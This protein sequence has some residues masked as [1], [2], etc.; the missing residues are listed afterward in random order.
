MSLPEAVRAVVVQENKTTA[1]KNVPIQ[2]PGENEILVKVKAVAINPTDWKHVKWPMLNKAGAY[3]GCDFAGEVVQVGPNLRANVKVGDRVASSVRGGVSRERGAFSEYAKTFADLTFV[4][5]EGTWSFEE[6]STIG[7]P[8]Y[9]SIQ[10]LYGPRTLGLPQ[11]GDRPPAPGTWF[12]V[13]GGSS[14]VGQYAIQ[15]AK[16]SGYK[17]ATVASPHNFGLVKGLGADV[18]FDYMDPGV[19]KKLK[20]ATGNDIHL[21]LDTISL[22]ETLTFTIRVLAEGTQGRVAILGF[23]S[24]EVKTLRKDVEVLFTLIYSAFGVRD[25][26]TVPNDA[27]RR[28]LSNFIGN[29]LPGLVREGKIKPNVITKWEGGLEKVPDAIEYLAAGKVSGE[30]IVFSKL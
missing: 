10:V 15:L 13:Y 1:V 18:V 29:K 22:D 16:L 12:F 14:S 27:E 2:T 23:V 3:S 6:A 20:E 25:E 9:T 24:D 26:A 7:I 11:P 4:I 19:V 5:P 21:A 17:V 28:N 8:L 30:K